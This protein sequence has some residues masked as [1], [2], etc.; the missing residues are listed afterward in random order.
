MDPNTPSHQS[1]PAAV[2]RVKSLRA[3]LGAPLPNLQN[4][5][6][7]ASWTGRASDIPKHRP[8]QNIPQDPDDTNPL[9]LSL[10]YIH[11]PPH[12]IT[13]ILCKNSFHSTTRMKS[14][15]I[16][17]LGCGMYMHVG[18]FEEEC[19]GPPENVGA[20]GDG[21]C[22]DSGSGSGSDSGSGGDSGLD[23]S[24]NKHRGCFV[25]SKPVGGKTQRL[26]GTAAKEQ[27]VGDLT[28]QSCRNFCRTETASNGGKPWKYF[29]IEY[30]RDCRCSN[31]LYY[32]VTDEPAKCTSRASGNSQ[33]R[34]GG[35]NYVDVWE[36]SGGSVCFSRCSLRLECSMLCNCLLFCFDPG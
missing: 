23:F 17:I 6:L 15:G 27:R 28:W 36:M 9:P 30:G 29:G 5:N 14:V 10:L 18:C 4:T 19:K 3:I 11:R 34:G 13:C 20:K 12:S 22:G 32:S 16:K 25:A 31:K 7:T 24:G 26:L 35:K 21:K 8:A 1:D 2:A 33:Q